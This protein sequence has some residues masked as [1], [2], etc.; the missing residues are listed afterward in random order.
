MVKRHVV[1]LTTLS[2]AAL[3]SLF[4]DGIRF[5]QRGALTAAYTDNQLPGARY[6]NGTRVVKIMVDDLS[7]THQLGAV[8]T[9]VGSI[10]HPQVGNAYFVGWD[11]DPNRPTMAV[12]KKLGLA[13]ENPDGGHLPVA[14][15]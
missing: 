15:Q 9:V 10:G 12:E 14:S 7:D 13:H 8:G 4:G 6:P 2:D 5:Y 1:D 3:R 11:D